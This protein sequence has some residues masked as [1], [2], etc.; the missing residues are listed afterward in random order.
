MKIIRWMDLI[1]TILR[2]GAWP[3]AGAS[4]Q[5][6]K[7]RSEIADFVLWVGGNFGNLPPKKV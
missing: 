7:C 4:T 3:E 2:D 1:Q 5:P 6:L